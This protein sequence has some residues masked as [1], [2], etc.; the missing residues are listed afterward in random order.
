MTRT[1]FLGGVAAFILTVP[2][3]AASV[4]TYT[5]NDFTTATGPLL[6]TGDSV[7]GSFTLA[8]PLGDNL[9]G[10]NIAPTALSFS[11]TDGPDTITN[12]TP[13]VNTC[14]CSPTIDIF[15]NGSGQIINWDI[16]LTVGE[17]GAENITTQDF[18]AGLFASGIQDSG[19]V[20][21]NPEG[22]DTASNSNDPGTWSAGA[23]NTS[24]PEP[25]S[26][27]LAAA[28]LL[29]IGFVRRKFYRQA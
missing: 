6:T 5:G 21:T 2:L 20:N 22:T 14:S 10:V 4:Y 25:G 8:S 27:I 12:T 29:T 19:S 24:V 1:K 28:G 11:F 17:L 7:T 23:S 18:D 13:G 26:M 3:T 15:T 9:D 16:S